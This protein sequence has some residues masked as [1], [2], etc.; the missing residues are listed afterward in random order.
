MAAKHEEQPAAVAVPHPDDLVRARSRQPLAVSA[1]GNRG[2][3]IAV[4]FVTEQLRSFLHIPDDQGIV[5]SRRREP[6]ATWI[7]A[8]AADG[9]GVALKCTD[10]FAGG[11]VPQQDA[12][13]FARCRG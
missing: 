2:D 5:V 10:A 3:A 8:Q 1:E 6:A 11:W 7:K 4:P 13:V 9:V 12:F